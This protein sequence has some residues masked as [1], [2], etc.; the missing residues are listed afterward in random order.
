MSEQ[1]YQELF[2]DIT[3]QRLR[4]GQKLTLKML[5]ER[6][7]VSHTPIREAL[8]RLAEAGLVT[9]YSNCGV[10]VVAFT[11]SDIRELYQFAAEMDAIAIQFCGD[12]FTQ[13]PLTLELRELVEEGQ[14]ALDAGD[15]RRWMACSEQFHI[16]LYRHARNS[17]LDRAAARMQAK[18]G[19]LA[20]LYYDERNMRKIHDGHVEILSL[21][22]KGEFTA[23]AARMRQH[24]QQD[25]AYALKAYRQRSV[26]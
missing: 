15:A 11:E 26:E 2:C 9:Y 19:L 1:I 13:T 21:V 5:K 6:F 22:E 20:C 23:A 8:M 17:Y 14:R 12:P 10:T 25:M 16:A 4:C 24:L 3:E 18:L 7:Q